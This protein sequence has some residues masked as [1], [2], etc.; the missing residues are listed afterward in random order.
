[1]PN[2]K[3]VNS[4]DTDLRS[5]ITYLCTKKQTNNPFALITFIVHCLLWVLPVG[6]GDWKSPNRHPS[7]SP[8]GNGKPI[9]CT[10][11]WHFISASHQ[12]LWP[13]IRILKEWIESTN[14]HTHTHRGSFD[15][16]LAW[17]PWQQWD[18]NRPGSE[19]QPLTL[20]S[21]VD[22]HLKSMIK[23]R[24]GKHWDR[25]QDSGCLLA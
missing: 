11:T 9:T 15:W 20:P 16:L 4:K 7:L 8:S 10:A 25:V 6:C 21:K 13:G 22:P 19:Q 14:Q 12:A 23:C 17:Q 2:Y 3:L 5:R 1:M 18:C 24:E